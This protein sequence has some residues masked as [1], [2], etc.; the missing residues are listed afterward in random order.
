VNVAAVQAAGPA[1]AAAQHVES[2][3]AI[4]DR[5]MAGGMQTAALGAALVLPE[6]RWQEPQ[7]QRNARDRGPW[8]SAAIA[9]GSA[10]AGIVAFGAARGPHTEQER[11]RSADEALARA[12][13]QTLNRAARLSRRVRQ[14][15][16]AAMPFAN[17]NSTP[18]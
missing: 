6:R 1:G 16:P 15:L 4:S 18:R 11:A 13:G 14:Q 17:S 2:F 5:A 3:A 7:P 8:D 10:L 12:S 9:G